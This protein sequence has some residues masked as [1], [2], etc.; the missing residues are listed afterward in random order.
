MTILM[1]RQQT[2]L[3]DDIPFQ[4]SYNMIESKRNTYIYINIVI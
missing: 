3:Q 4:F 1:F 2:L